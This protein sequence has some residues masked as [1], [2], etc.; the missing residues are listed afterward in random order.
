[1]TVTRLDV[2]SM[3]TRAGEGSMGAELLA[4]GSAV[5][6]GGAEWVEGAGSSRREHAKSASDRPT[7]IACQVAVR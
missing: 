4:V 2:G 3:R 1:M 5:V 7:A 6:G